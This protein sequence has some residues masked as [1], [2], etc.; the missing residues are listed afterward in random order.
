MAD[1]DISSQTKEELLEV[2]KKQNRII[3][4]Y[5]GWMKLKN[6]N[7]GVFNFIWDNQFKKIAVYGM[8]RLGKS[9]CEEL[10]ANGFRSVYVI[11]RDHNVKCNRYPLY[12]IEDELPETDV[13][14]ITSLASYEEIVD[15]LAKKL[16][17]P[18]LSLEDILS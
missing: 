17:C 2:I 16:K 10:S 5:S 1:K 13:V 18:L 6:M 7:R 9:L 8:S 12:S 3:D 4:A 14:F 15:E 11:D